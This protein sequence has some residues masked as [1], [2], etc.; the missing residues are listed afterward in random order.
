MKESTLTTLVFSVLALAGAV[1]LL[2]VA[3]SRSDLA[4]ISCADRPGAHAC[5]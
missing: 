2:I 1:S 3:P 5:R 4:A